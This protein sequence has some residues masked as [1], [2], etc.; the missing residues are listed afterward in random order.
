MGV[1]RWHSEWGALFRAFWPGPVETESQESRGPQL[2]RHLCQVLSRSLSPSDAENSISA[3][4]TKMVSVR[5]GAWGGSER[6]LEAGRFQHVSS[7][8]SMAAHLCWTMTPSHGPSLRPST[9][10]PSHYHPPHTHTLSFSLP[11]SVTGQVPALSFICYTRHATSP[12]VPQFP[13]W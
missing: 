4:C 6:E 3:V 12:L 10:G 11:K 2:S 7:G 9:K 5:G 8:H 1:G 13:H